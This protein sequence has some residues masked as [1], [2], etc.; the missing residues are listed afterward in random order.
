M[1]KTLQGI[2]SVF[3]INRVK[4]EQLNFKRNLNFGPKNYLC[5]V[6]CIFKI[7]PSPITRSTP[8]SISIK[9]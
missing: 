4:I 6:H 3:D 2:K 5:E 1:Q 9:N 8:F 7:R